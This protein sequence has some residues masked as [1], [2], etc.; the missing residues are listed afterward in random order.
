[1]TI[2]DRKEKALLQKELVDLLT[3]C[4]NDTAYLKRL[5][6]AQEIITDAI[7]EFSNEEYMKVVMQL[8]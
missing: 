5:I 6:L 2:N 8:R 1:M 4:P 3:N 7:E